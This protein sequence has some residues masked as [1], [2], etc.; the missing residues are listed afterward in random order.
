MRKVLL[1][2][3]FV[4]LSSCAAAPGPEFTGE[5]LEISSDQL[6]EYWVPEQ[7]TVKFTFRSR[8]KLPEACG[9][10][11]VEY[12][13]DSNGDIFDPTIMESQP[14]GAHEKSVLMM[15]SE[16]KYL[17]SDVNPDRTPVKITR[18]TDFNTTN[19]KCLES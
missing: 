11:V 10:V 8:S 5:I 15:L 17:P 9:Y 13:I 12:L 19:G 16:M 18:R 2:S 3:T 4:T 7:D 6:S 14:K 1:V